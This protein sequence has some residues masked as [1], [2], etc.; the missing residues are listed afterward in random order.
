VAIFQTARAQR[1]SASHAQQHR[2]IKSW[3]DG[4]QFFDPNANGEIDASWW[5]RPYCGG[6]TFTSIG[7]Q[8]SQSHRAARSFLWCGVHSDPNANGDVLSITP[9]QQNGTFWWVAVSTPIGGQT[10]NT[11]PAGS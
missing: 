7:G 2:A 11:L 4:R 6:G 5:S 8:T 1:R 10:R 3:T 9:Q